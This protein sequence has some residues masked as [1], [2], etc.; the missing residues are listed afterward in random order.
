MPMIELL[1]SK[2]ENRTGYTRYSQGLERDSLNKTATGVNRIMDASQKRMKLMA[3]IMA[4]AL[5]A[6]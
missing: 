5:V 4:E 6:P 2:K 1:E 3:R